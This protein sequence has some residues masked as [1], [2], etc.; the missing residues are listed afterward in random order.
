MAFKVKNIYAV[1]YRVHDWK[2]NLGLSPNLEKFV[3]ADRVLESHTS[4]RL[5]YQ[6]VG[7]NMV[8]DFNGV[9]YREARVTF[10]DYGLENWIQ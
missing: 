2:Y 6:L 8:W 3:S 4:Y 7:R 9:V 10:S 5:R 1:R